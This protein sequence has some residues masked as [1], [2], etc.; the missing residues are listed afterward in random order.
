MEIVSADE[1]EMPR[2]EEGA[3]QRTIT[4]SDQNEEFERRFAGV[5]DR[6]GRVVASLIGPTD[7][8]DVVHDTYLIARKRLSQ[9]RD[10][11]ALEAWLFR[12]AINTAY[13]RKRRDRREAL[14]LPRLAGRARAPTD[15]DL[16]LIELVESLP[17]AE[18][19]LVVLHYG[20]GYRLDEVGQ[21]VGLTEGAVKAKL[22][23]ARRRLLRQLVE[24]SD[25]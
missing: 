22:F 5:R 1:F 25:V 13:S 8:D 18:R 7:A 2:T 19:T 11:S 16:A 23:R 20:H 24:A 9:L 12:I 15:R 3:D 17:P 14:A 21:L 6:L 4:G 10:S